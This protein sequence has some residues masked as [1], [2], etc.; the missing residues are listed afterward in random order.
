MTPTRSSLRLVLRSM[1]IFVLCSTFAVTVVL[2][3]ASPALAQPSENAA[4]AVL[5][6]VAADR[7]RIRAH[8]E[9]VERELRARD[10][11]S[12][13]PSARSARARALD[14]LHAYSARGVFPRNTRHPGERIPYF[15]DDEGRACAMAHLIQASGAPALAETVR[16]RENN[17]RVAAMTTDLGPWLE[18]NGLTAEEAARIQPDYCQCGYVYNPVCADVLVGDGGYER[19]TF[20][21]EC[22][23]TL[24]TSTRVLYEGECAPGDEPADSACDRGAC[25]ESSE[26][27]CSLG[28]APGHHG[29]FS[30][31]PALGLLGLLVVL[32]RRAVRRL[33]R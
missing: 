11:S 2:A 28:P 31:V 17:A 1:S 5:D 19:K 4:P 3:K 33:R 6:A 10:T 21:N 8:L 18:E 9:Q 7:L 30:S 25:K 14:A 13:A 23:A 27:T 29:P 32:L 16:V 12:L 22:V 15:I 26:S 24:C 20:L